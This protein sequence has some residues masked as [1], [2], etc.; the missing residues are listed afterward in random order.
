MSASLQKTSQ[1]NI[2]LS[3]NSQTNYGEVMADAALTQ[4]QR[5][6][7]SSAF[8]V[9]PSGRTD[10]SMA[11]KGTEFATDYTDTSWD[12]DGTLK[13]QADT[14]FTAWA[15]AFAFGADTVTGAGP[16][17]HSFTIPQTTPTMPCTCVYVEET[18]DQKRKFQDM[19]IKTVSIDIPERGPI[20]VSVDL[21]GT[22]RW[23]PGAMAAG[24][25][26]LAAETILLGSDVSISLTPAGAAANTYSGQLKGASVKLDRGTAPYEA[27]G[28]GLY[29]G[30]NV[31]G[32]TKYSCD[33]TIAAAAAD[34][35]NGIFEAG[36]ICAVTLG[37]NPAL[38]QKMS[39]FWPAV[40]IKANKVGNANG[41]VTWAC[42]FDEMSS[43]GVIG[44][45]AAISASLTNT[46]PAYLA[47]A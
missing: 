43:Y 44:G 4:R 3:V 47:A 46:V 10:K 34:D 35:I 5:F 32:D 11:G 39:F 40:R 22:G 14:W 31:S 24:P 42:S 9:K 18:A 19:S 21:V 38:A 29:A 16:Y 1:R 26:A 7:P 33:F 30:Q 37:T 15:L 23:T 12:T 45:A 25:P 27:N 20:M 8:T 41:I 6:D 28:D 17:T 36:T 13:Y 2:V